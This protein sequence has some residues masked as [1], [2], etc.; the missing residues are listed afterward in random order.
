MPIRDST[1]LDGAALGKLRD[2]IVGAFD[3]NELEMLVKITLSEGLYDKY[4]QPG[5][6]LNYAVFKLLEALERRGTT[7]L[8]L[9]AVRRAR[10]DKED[11]EQ[12]IR[13]IYPEALTLDEDRSAEKEIKEVRETTKKQVDFVVS[14]VETMRDHLT[15]NAVRDLV[16]TSRDDLERLTANIKLLAA[17]KTLHDCL[18][19]IQ[20]SHYRSL[21]RHVKVFRTEPNA[22]SELE[23]LVAQLKPLVQDAREAAD[24]LPDT[25]TSRARELDWVIRLDAAVTLLGT[26]VENLQDRDALLAVR[27]LR[28]IIRVEPFNVNR[29]LTLIAEALPLD[30]LIVTVERVINAAAPT[31]EALVDHLESALNALQNLLPQLKGRV[32]EHKRWQTVENEFWGAEEFLDR[33]TPDAIEEFLLLWQTAKQMV[34]ELR[35]IDPAANWA[36][37]AGKFADKLDQDVPQDAQPESLTDK[38]PIVRTNYG[39]F[40]HR[41]LDHFYRVDKVLKSQCEEILRLGE[42]LRSRL[43][44]V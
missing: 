2:L 42:P 33:G 26:A 29:E 24:S 40:R 38:L 6:A 11:V 3:K 39:R 8:L 15:N 7:I 32:A 23:D 9:R 10:P 21:T 20:L 37:E 27:S 30:R 18:H 13:L 34:Q 19:K 4:I 36:I 22:A 1:K 28:T 41:V 12:T 43:R 16:V 25:A 35:A 31:D 14:G 5:V 44:E 17:Y